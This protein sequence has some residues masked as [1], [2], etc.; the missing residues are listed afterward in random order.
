MVLYLYYAGKS[1]PCQSTSQT[2]LDPITTAKPN[3]DLT[4]VLSRPFN[5]DGTGH[6]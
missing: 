6:F 3:Q 1:V 4:P 2:K 5:G